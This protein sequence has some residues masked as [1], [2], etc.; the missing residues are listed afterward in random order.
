MIYLKKNNVLGSLK[1]VDSFSSGVHQY[2]GA[3]K[4]NL[5][6]NILLFVF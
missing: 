5:G 1:C 2:E 4:P 3:F 6:N